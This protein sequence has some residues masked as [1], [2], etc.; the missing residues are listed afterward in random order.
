MKHP[1]AT[2]RNGKIVYVDLVNS[3]AAITIAQQPHLATLVKEVLQQTK[4]STPT[5]CIE[6]DMRRPIGYD[7]VVETSDDANVFYAKLL[8]DPHYTR[9]I[10]N[11]KPLATNYLSIMLEEKAD[12]EGDYQLKDVWIGKNRPARPECDNET[13]DSRDFWAHHAFVLEGQQVQPRT[14][15]R[16]CPY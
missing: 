12:K 8:R 3:A 11:G 13:A 10:K 9:L 1:V 7:N 16:T 2:T 5:M 4:V 14:L 15:T 6:Q